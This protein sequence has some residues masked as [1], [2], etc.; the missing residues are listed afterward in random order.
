MQRNAQREFEDGHI[1]SATFFDIDEI[2]DVKSP[3]PHMLPSPE[4]FESGTHSLNNLG[5]KYLF[6]RRL[7]FSQR[8]NSVSDAIF[9][10]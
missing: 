1:P 5:F 8:V 3:F 2:K 9:I 10:H 4:Q 7:F 6:V